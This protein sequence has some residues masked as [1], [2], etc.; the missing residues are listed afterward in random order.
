MLFYFIAFALCEVEI[1]YGVN[2]TWFPFCNLVLTALI[3]FLNEYNMSQ[4]MSSQQDSCKG[5]CHL[6]ILVNL[7]LYFHW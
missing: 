4:A 3:T 6:S 2:V 5:I 7:T 1:E